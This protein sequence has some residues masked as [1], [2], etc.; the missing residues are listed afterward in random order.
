MTYGGFCLIGLLLACLAVTS[1][2][3]LQNRP[4]PVCPK[5]GELR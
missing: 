5:W 4:A 1:A 3:A 2:L